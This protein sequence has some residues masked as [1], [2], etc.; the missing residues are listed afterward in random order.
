[1]EL[2]GVDVSHWQGPINW[3]E[4]K[5]TGIDFAILKAGGSD[6]GFYKDSTFERNYADAKSVGMNVGAY[7]FVGKDFV[8]SEDGIADAKRFIELLQGKQFEYPVYVDIE[9]TS[10]VDKIGVTDATIS[11][12][13]EMEN[14]GYFVGIYGSDLA[15][16]FSRVDNTKLNDF[17]RWV[18]RYGNEPKYVTTYGVWQY[19]SSGSING[20]LGNVDMNICY[21]DYPTIIK[22]AGLNGF[23]KPVEVSQEPQSNKYKVGDYVSFNGIY[24]SVSSTQKLYPYFT[25]GKITA[26][27]EGKNPYLINEGMGWVNDDV[28]TSVENNTHKVEE[29]TYIVQ[30][31][32]SLWKIAENLLGDGSRY[33]ELAKINNIVDP[34]KIYPGQVLII[35]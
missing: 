23:S 7:Y 35:P 14:N 3:Q 31:N 17:A 22:S 33:E 15:T 18:A 32:D 28:I 27:K 30:T 1:M 24:E 9:I 26:I 34:N 6:D 20:I 2:K 8:S 10:P 4:V 11:F 16:F 29:N 13:R 12:C 5:E 25:S 21:I 19:S